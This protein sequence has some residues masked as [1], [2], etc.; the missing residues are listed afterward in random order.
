MKRDLLYDFVAES[1]KIEGIRY[2][3]E[4]EVDVHNGM[5]H[6][7]KITIWDLQDFVKVV[8]PNAKLRDSTNVA[9]VRVGN[10]VAPPSGPEIRIQLEA[11]LKVSDPWEQHCLYEDLHPFTDGNGR[12][13]RMLWLW[14][15]RNNYAMLERGFLHNFYYQTLASRR[16]LEL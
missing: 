14:R 12:S 11:I 3:T 1:N 10:H 8:Q 9:G 4:E 13:G 15:H 7:D 2:T 16:K 5:L 6:L